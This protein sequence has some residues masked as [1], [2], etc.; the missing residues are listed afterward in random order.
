HGDAEG[1]ALEAAGAG[2]AEVERP[3]PAPAAHEQRLQL[4]R[5]HSRHHAVLERGALVGQV[6]AG[7]RVFDEVVQQLAHEA[8]IPPSP[9]GT[10]ARVWRRQDVSEP[11]SRSSLS[12]SGSWP[13]RR[14]SW[15]VRGAGWDGGRSERGSWSCWRGRRTWES[16][17]SSSH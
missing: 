13:W 7:A 9:G 4:L 2:G 14:C 11:R 8:S 12:S 16:P 6:V 10:L 17:P 5:A 3:E 15:P 1:H